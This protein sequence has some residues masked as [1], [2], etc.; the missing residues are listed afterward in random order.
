MT[1]FI[2]LRRWIFKRGSKRRN[3]LFVKSSKGMPES[4]S[5]IKCDFR[6][7]LAINI[8]SRT[9]PPVFLFKYAFLNPIK[10]SK[11]KTNYTTYDMMSSVIFTF[12]SKLPSVPNAR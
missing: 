5:M 8:G 12:G 11:E 10:T 6:Y 2:C 7:F 4:K 3:Q 1:R 9:S